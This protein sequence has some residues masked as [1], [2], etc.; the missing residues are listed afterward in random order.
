MQEAAESYRGRHSVIVRRNEKNLGVL[1]HV[2][3]VAGIASGEFLVVAA[4]DD[5][6]FPDRTE[7]QVC[8]LMGAGSDVAVVSGADIVFDSGGD[9]GR[10]EWS[11][12]TLRKWLSEMNAWF[13]GATACYRISVLRRLPIPSEVI[14]RE[15][16]AMMAFFEGC[17]YY[18]KYLEEPLI[19]RRAHG[20]NIGLEM[21]LEDPW[22]NELRIIRRLRHIAETWDYSARA[23]E[24]AGFDA[25][26]IRSRAS[27]LRQYVRWRDM[28]FGERLNLLINSLR[29]RYL[30]KSSLYVVFGRGAFVFAKSLRRTL[31][32]CRGCL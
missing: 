5:I 28:G 11:V 29:F 22:E 7:R 15:D 31:R 24:G 16:M 19:R 21:D 4:G 3:A 32:G 12:E 30:R 26:V 2:L 1:G 14:L 27:I 18:S 13:H 23:I 25:G 10:A 17:G 8:C 20:R 9:W 6:S